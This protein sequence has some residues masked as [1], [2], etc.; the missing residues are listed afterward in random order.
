[1]LIRC[2]RKRCA[3]SL[4]LGTLFGVAVGCGGQISNMPPT[5]SAT[6]SVHYKGGTPVAGGAI[7][8]IPL[9][10]NTLSVSGEINDDGSFTLYTVK[11]SEKT[12]GA[13]EG[14][15]RVTVQP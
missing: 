12:K 7:L 4:V 10:D 13:P 6:G 5:F 3:G 9:T 15:Y 14:G 1:M 11:G 2:L 8:F